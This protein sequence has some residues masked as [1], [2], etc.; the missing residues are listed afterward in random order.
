[1]LAD[2]SR[3]LSA[4][5]ERELP[6]LNQ[7]TDERSSLKPA[8]SGWSPKEE[9]GHLIDSAVNNHQRF[10]RAAIHGEFRGPG[11]AQDD[12]VKTNGYQS[13]A[14]DR[15]VDLWYRLNELL[16]HAVAHIPEASAQSPVTVGQDSVKPLDYIVDDYILHLQH[17]VDHLLSRE[18]ITPYPALTPASKTL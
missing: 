7:L 14:W 16:V 13:L 17:H 5:I 1:M 6:L 3:K 2:L 18:K 12:W 9:L 10:V 8:T 15:V 4:T 11:Y